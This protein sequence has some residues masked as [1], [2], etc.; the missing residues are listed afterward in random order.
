MDKFNGPAPDLSGD[1]SRAFKACVDR[2]RDN[3]LGCDA[4]DEEAPY[5]T[6][7]KEEDINLGFKLPPPPSL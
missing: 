6:C 7:M 3:S 1:G 2:L 4:I 5:L